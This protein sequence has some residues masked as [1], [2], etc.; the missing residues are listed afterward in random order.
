MCSKL[1]KQAFEPTKQAHC[2]V[3]KR[4]HMEVLLLPSKKIFNEV[5]DIIWYS[6]YGANGTLCKTWE[7]SQVEIGL[8]VNMKV[9]MA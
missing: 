3:K 2:A 9:P 7:H 4:L 5:Q 6:H 8:K 1:T